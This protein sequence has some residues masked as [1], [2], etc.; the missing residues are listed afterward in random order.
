M[1]L[2][3]FNN[4]RFDIAQ[5]MVDREN[6]DTFIANRSTHYYPEFKIASLETA[7][8][9]SFECVP[10]YCFELTGRTLPFGCHAWPKYDRAFWEPYLLLA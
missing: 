5:Y 6:N 10:R 8:R 4:V 7:L 3:R 2:R 1:R 9:F